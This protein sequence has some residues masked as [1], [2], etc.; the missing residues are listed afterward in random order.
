MADFI[1]LSLSRSSHMYASNVFRT[2]DS[3]YCRQ[4]SLLDYWHR[5]SHCWT[6]LRALL[7]L[8]LHLCPCPSPTAAQYSHIAGSK[9]M[10]GWW[11]CLQQVYGDGRPALV[12]AQLLSIYTGVLMMLL[13]EHIDTVHRRWRWLSEALLGNRLSFRLLFDTHFRQ[14]LLK[15]QSKR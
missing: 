15:Q 14:T 6:I 13:A 4:Q 12:T 11:C 7:L 3:K 10:D 5:V 2:R 1:L 9:P 8:E